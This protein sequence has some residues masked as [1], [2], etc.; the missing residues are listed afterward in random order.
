[1]CDKRSYCVLDA[2]FQPPILHHIDA[3]VWLP[4]PEDM[5]PFE[6]LH[7]DHVFAKFQEQW[8][9][10]VAQDPAG[11]RAHTWEPS[12]KNSL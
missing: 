4:R 8:L 6:Q 7:K 3:G 11:T 1:M 5:L 2:D 12:R 9:L 10:K